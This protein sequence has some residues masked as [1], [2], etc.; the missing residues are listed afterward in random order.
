M[1]E[2]IGGLLKKD[3]SL[4]V[5]CFFF[6]FFLWGLFVV[7]VVVAVVVVFIWGWDGGER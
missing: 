4:R 6:C 5:D 3:L 7:V 2:T 1:R